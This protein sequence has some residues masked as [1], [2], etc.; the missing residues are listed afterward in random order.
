MYNIIPP[1]QAF[2]SSQIKNCSSGKLLSSF[3]S[4]L[5]SQTPLNYF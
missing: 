4:D 3:A 1:T 5:G 2:Q